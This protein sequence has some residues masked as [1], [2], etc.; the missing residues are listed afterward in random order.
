MQHNSP[1]DH[2]V[3]L[4]LDH[5]PTNHVH[6]TDLIHKL[7]DSVAKHVHERPDS[8]QYR[9]HDDRQPAETWTGESGHAGTH[10]ELKT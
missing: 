3:G 4:L 7:L 1:E 6:I 5:L 9:A 8:Q 2:A 10:L